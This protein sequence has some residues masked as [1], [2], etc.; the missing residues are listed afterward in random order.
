MKKIGNFEYDPTVIEKLCRENDISYLALFGSYLHGDN[1][2]DSDVDL[3]VKFDKPIGLIKLVG[4]EQQLESVL[5]KEID[6]LTEGFLSPYF[7][8]E[9]LQ[10]AQTI[11]QS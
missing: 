5:G 11:Y 3:L 7:K 10:E 9:V 1:K 2:A 6:L 4:T 8:N